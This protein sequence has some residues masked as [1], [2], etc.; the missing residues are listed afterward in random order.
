MLAILALLIAI[1]L[2]RSSHDGQSA[3]SSRAPSIPAKPT[4]RTPK[5]PELSGDGNNAFPPNEKPVSEVGH[6]V[7][8]QV[9]N[10]DGSAIA[11]TVVKLLRTL[12]DT[13][14]SVTNE[15]GAFEFK[16][17]P[18]GMYQVSTVMSAMPEVVIGIDMP[19]DRDLEGLRLCLPPTWDIEVALQDPHGLPVQGTAKASTER[20]GYSAETDENGIAHFRLGECA[21][22][23]FSASS[24]ESAKLLLPAN[25]VRL[26][27]G[28]QTLTLTLVSG[29]VAAG[30]LLW[31]DGSPMS[32]YGVRALVGDSVVSETTADGQGAFEILVPAVGECVLA[33]E[34]DWVST[35]EDEERRAEGQLSG[36]RA[37]DIG[38][39]F[40]TSWI[41]MDRSLSVQVSGPDGPVEQ[42][43]VVIKMHGDVQGIAS[44]LTDS[45]G[46]WS[47]ESLPRGDLFVEVYS[48]AVPPLWSPNRILAGPDSRSL[49][50]KLKPG[51][52]IRGT[53]R[54]SDG[55]KI[56]RAD[57]QVLCGTEVVAS[58]EG[59]TF[60]SFSVVVP[61]DV[62]GPLEVRATAICGKLCYAGAKAAQIDLDSE[63]VV[64]LKRDDLK[65]APGWRWRR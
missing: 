58:W 19:A 17:V 57:G 45:S 47:S 1:A 41:A 24:R 52:E 21:Y 34:S 56:D 49:D 27:R 62:D 35:G 26:S 15:N 36:V 8:G 50:V 20:Q 5:E 40:R 28:Q 30:R 33:L 6:K 13:N 63:V 48:E 46:R 12:T 3:G 9:L 42:A 4:E 25:P 53:L 60:D 55:F 32:E 44:G 11:Y 23:V 18:A 31:P 39:Q 61:A 38:L 22:A 65:S 7:L 43:L 59:H 51:V 10:A 29:G 2:R 54:I 14:Y 37:G 16:E 64:D